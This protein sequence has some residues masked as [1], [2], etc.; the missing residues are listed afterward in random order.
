MTERMTIHWELRR[1]K[2]FQHFRVHCC[3]GAPKLCSAALYAYLRA[4]AF[5]R[6]FSEG[7]RKK[8]RWRQQA[9]AGCCASGLRRL[10]FS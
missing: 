5:G 9:H 10:L 4:P 6:R 1:G 2:A 3:T 7:R 8:V